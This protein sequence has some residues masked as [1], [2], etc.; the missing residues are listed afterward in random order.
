MELR[1]LPRVA[2]HPE[3]NIGYLDRGLDHDLD[4][5]QV[6]IQDLLVRG[7]LVDRGVDTVE[8]V[9]DTEE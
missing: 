6:D 7:V 5:D 2:G 8:D 1:A 9:T 4:L 3:D